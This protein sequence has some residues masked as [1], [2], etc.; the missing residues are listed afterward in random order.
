MTVPTGATTGPIAAT[1]PSGSATS[2]TAFTVTV[3]P[4]ISGFTPSSGPVGTSV[5]IAGTGFSATPAENSVTFNGTAATITSSTPTSID[6]TV[7]TGATTGPVAVTSPSGSATSATA[8]TVT[9]PEP[10]PPTISGFS[11]T[12]GVAGTSVT[13]SGTNFALVPANNQ[14]KFNNTAAMPSGSTSTTVTAP[15]P[16]NTSS[17]R[18]RI[19]TPAGTA[20][21]AG[22]FIIPPAAFVAEDVV[23][24]G[25]IAFGSP[26]PVSVSTA[27]KIGLFLFDGTS[28]Q[29]V[30]LLGT[31]GLTGQVFG[32]DINVS[33]LKPDATV[34]APATCM[35]QTGFIDV[36]T[37]PSTGTYTILVDPAGTAAGGVTLTLY[38]V[39]ADVS[40]T[41]N[42]AGPSL[43]ATMSVPGQN[44][45]LTFSGTA[46]QRV[47]LVGTNGMTGQ[48]GF[49]CDVNVTIRKPDATVLVPATCMEQSGYVD[50]LTLPST[51][52]YQVSIDPMS[53]AV[54]NLTLR[55]YDVPA[56][57]TGTLTPGGPS[58]T[59]TMSVPGQNGVLTFSGTAGQRVS[60]A[61]TDGIAG[62]VGFACD[63]NVTIRKPDAT[64]LV[65]ATCMEQ[66]GYVDALTLPST[67]TYQVSIDPMSW[68]VGSLTLTLYDVPADV[69]GTLVPGG[70]SRD[71]D[72]VGAGPERR[73]HVLGDRRAESVVAGY[74]RA[75]GS[76]SLGATS[77]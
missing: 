30:S 26:T 29:R 2:A 75:D 43:T 22:D 64:V 18:I 68:A 59:A 3:P 7:P 35:E 56:D 55:L 47:S 71:G 34:L 6:V 13:I 40:G 27:N 4:A 41:L 10:E 14:T 72:D 24:S 67:G 25:R 61:G 51:G 19:T 9:V 70:A 53:W 74:E 57:V 62:Q 58:V 17:G 33:I 50:A 48:V 66:S 49:A 76:R 37:L 16:A 11:P 52:T 42:P 63:V 31:N 1:S 12:I 69:T 28:G 39:P 54:G 20:V 46:G 44:G 73:P 23:T 60:L 15:V 45:V 32:C 77:T 21:S 65:P 8:F 38:D 5:T 36:Q